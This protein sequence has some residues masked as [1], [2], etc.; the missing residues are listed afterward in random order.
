MTT[1]SSETKIA[2]IAA[3]AICR[4]KL[5]E[6]VVAPGAVVWNRFSSA[7]V[8]CDSFGPLS[9]FVRIWKLLYALLVDGPRP[10]MT[11]SA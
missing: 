1:R 4:P 10:W 8:T 7:R 2:M 3:L 6:T 11:A 5:D 9:A